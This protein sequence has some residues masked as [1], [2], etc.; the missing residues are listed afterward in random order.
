MLKIW[1]IQTVHIKSDENDN[2]III[3]KEILVQAKEQLSKKCAWEP[4]NILEENILELG[5]L[6]IA[7]DLLK[8]GGAYAK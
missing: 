6:S 4:R 3:N 2:D 1:N 7:H 5:I 8:K